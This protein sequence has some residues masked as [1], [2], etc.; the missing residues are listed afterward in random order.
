MQ[1]VELV[2]NSGDQIGAI[3][4]SAFPFTGLRHYMTAY[5]R[6]ALEEYKLFETDLLVFRLGKDAI[7]S[8]FG[9]RASSGHENTFD[10]F[11]NHARLEINRNINLETLDPRITS[12]VSKRLFE[13]LGER[14]AHIEVVAKSA[15]DNAMVLGLMEKARSHNITTEAS[16]D[17][18]RGHEHLTRSLNSGHRQ[19]VKRGL[20]RLGNDIRVFHMEE[21]SDAISKFRDLHERAAGRVT[22]PEESWMLMEKA[23]YEGKAILTVAGYSTEMLGATF[24]WLGSGCAVWYRCIR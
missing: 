22:R 1:S 5:Y 13:Y 12:Q 21:A 16:T 24:T 23:V 2:A 14:G 15:A 3:D 20:E 18:S 4:Q 11:G 7:L 6:A 17:P 10:Y 8:L 9:T 19:S